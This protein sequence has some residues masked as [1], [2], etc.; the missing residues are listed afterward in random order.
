M[1]FFK[2]IKK[3][4][5]NIDADWM[6]A[7]D[8]G[9]GS[10]LLAFALHTGVVGLINWIVLLSWLSWNSIIWPK[11]DTW[12]PNEIGTRSTWSKDVDPLQAEPTTISWT[13]NWVVLIRHTAACPSGQ[14]HACVSHDPL[15]SNTPVQSGVGKPWLIVHWW[16]VEFELSTHLCGYRLRQ[17]D[18]HDADVHSG[19]ITEPWNAGLQDL[20]VQ[21]WHVHTSPL[22]S[23]TLTK[24]IRR[25]V[26]N[27]VLFNIVTQ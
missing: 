9:G 12:R 7:E 23:R 22:Q 5:R 13:R 1:S 18:L 15:M 6:T 17:I 19:T 8:I 20:P 3:N 24:I 16:K 26:Q 21:H 10:C 25:I 14:Q 11:N 4:N 2:L 27:I